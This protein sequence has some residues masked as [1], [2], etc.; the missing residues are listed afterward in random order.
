MEIEISSRF[1]D[2]EAASAAADRIRATEGITEMRLRWATSYVDV[3]FDNDLR[4]GPED[5]VLPPQSPSHFRTPSISPEWG[6]AFSNMLIPEFSTECI[7]L[8][9]TGSR[10][11]AEKVKATAIN[12]GG[13]DIKIKF[14]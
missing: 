12:G 5:A 10:K 11:T 8:V 1:R 6:G 9:R 4:Y 2:T 14:S 13:F 3:R 7:L